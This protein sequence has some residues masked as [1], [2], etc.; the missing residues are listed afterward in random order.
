MWSRMGMRTRMALKTR[1]GMVAEGYAVTDRYAA[2]ALFSLARR[3]F[4][5]FFEEAA[6]D[7]FRRG[8]EQAL[9]HT[10]DRPSYLNIAVVSHFG[11]L[12][13]WLEFEESFTFNETDFTAAFHHQP[14]TGRRCSI[15]DPHLAG[16]QAGDAGQH[17]LHFHFVF[18]FPDL[19]EGV[20]AGHTFG[21]H[22]GILQ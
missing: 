20:C 1:M 4:V 22:N 18:V 8:I 5:E 16:K 17:Q 21:Q 10:G 2:A 15:G 11:A 3:F 14:E 7:H 9:A 6:D 19:L 13:V 12:R